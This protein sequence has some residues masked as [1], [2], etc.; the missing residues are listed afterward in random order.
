MVGEERRKGGSLEEVG[1]K[2]MRVW[3]LGS[4]E[5]SI[6]LWLVNKL[7]LEISI[8]LWLVNKLRD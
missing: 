8:K 2:K 3:V 6:K 7:S 4:L 1:A 5:I